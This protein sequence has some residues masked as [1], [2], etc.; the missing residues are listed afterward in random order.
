[1]LL[2]HR[3]PTSY[4][5]GH[6][7]TLPYPAEPPVKQHNLIPQFTMRLPLHAQES[8]GIDSLKDQWFVVKIKTWKKKCSDGKFF[9]QMKIN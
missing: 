6:Q 2:F 5:Q 8:E 1:M 9:C 4:V 7:L 3:S